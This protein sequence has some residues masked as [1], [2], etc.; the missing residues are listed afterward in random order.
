MIAICTYNHKIAKGK[1]PDRPHTTY[2]PWKLELGFGSW[3]LEMRV[4]YWN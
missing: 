2:T 3:K 1:T 4:R